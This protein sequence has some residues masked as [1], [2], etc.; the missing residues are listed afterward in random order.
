[1]QTGLVISNLHNF[2]RLLLRRFFTVYFL[3]FII[4]FPLSYLPFVKII[5]KWYNHAVSKCVA[6]FGKYIFHIPFPLVAANNGSSDTTFNYI[7]LL[8]FVVLAIV[9]AVG[10]TLKEK[11]RKYDALVWHWLK[12]YIRFFFAF[13]MIQYGFEKILRTQF[14]FPYYSLNETYGQS[15]PMRLMW[16]FMGYSKAYSFFIGGGEVLA[17]FLVLFRKTTL[18]GAL[19]SIAI[20]SNVVIMNFCYDVPV[21]LFAS[22]LLFLSFFIAAPDAKRLYT[23]FVQNQTV[24]AAAIQP[25][26]KEAKTNSTL[27]AVKFV[28]AVVIVYSMIGNTKRKYYYYGDGAFTKAPLFGLYNV[29]TFIKNGDTLQPLITDTSQWRAL[30]IVYNRQAT[31]RIM[32]D[33]IKV[34]H[35]I[36]DTT[37]K[38][39]RLVEDK[40][41]TYKAFF[42]YSL[43]NSTHLLLTG[44]VNEDSVF[45]QLQKQN[46]QQFRLINR[47][48]HWIN[49]YPYKK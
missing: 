38:N 43:P 29:E 7:R 28:L 31:L 14:P 5:S 41:S 49:E 1:M 45:I 15:A 4:P 32:N 9:V 21:K 3:L 25:P 36:I 17:G 34:C 8:L 19:L 22:H 23:F 48:F 2:W 40:D 46:W 6:F 12:T 20:L 33:S 30:N 44:K 10:Y 47:G 39:L 42:S 27:Y 37:K 13:M 16:S 11:N 35:L 24:P 26:F 18:L